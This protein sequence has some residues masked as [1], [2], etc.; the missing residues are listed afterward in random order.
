[1]R[2]HS[3]RRCESCSFRVSGEF[4]AYRTLSCLPAMQRR[5]DDDV[6]ASAKF[7]GLRQCS[8]NRDSPRLFFHFLISLF[9]FQIFLILHISFFLLETH[10][11]LWWLSNKQQRERENANEVRAAL[12][13]FCRKTW[14]NVLQFFT[15]TSLVV[16]KSWNFYFF[17]STAASATAV[18]VGETGISVQVENGRWLN[19]CFERAKEFCY[20]FMSFSSANSAIRNPLERAKSAHN[21]IA[22]NFPAQS[23]LNDVRVMLA[24][25]ILHVFEYTPKR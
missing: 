20:D 12:A 8:Q 24:R 23:S 6:G 7:F 11:S 18:W 5:S 21:K 19:S 9:Q 16:L 15:L 2:V 3:R 14:N 13:R 4:V 1:M 17:V 25:L 22:H 10:S